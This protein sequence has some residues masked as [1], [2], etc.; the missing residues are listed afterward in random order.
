MPQ[1]I[2]TNKEPSI[3]TVE[4]ANPRFRVDRGARSQT[5]LPIL[6][7]FR[8]VVRVNRFCPLPAL[9]LFRSHARIIEPH[10]IEEVTVAVRTSSPCRRG[11]R[12]DDGGKAALARLQGLFGA[13]LFAQIEHESDALV[14][15]LF[16]QC[17]A[18]QHRNAAAIFT[19]ELLFIGL[20]SADVR[21]LC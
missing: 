2:G 20:D 9:R 8:T 19:E 21:E 6:D 4:V 14:S 7:K 10:P 1:W 5:R 17:A 13:F 16:E 3:G 12:I 11:D 15:T 18:S